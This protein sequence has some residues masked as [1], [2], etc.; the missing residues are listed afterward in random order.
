MS[1]LDVEK[2]VEGNK[3]GIEE[4]SPRGVLEDS[5]VSLDLKA[6]SKPSTSNSLESET[7]SPRASTSGSEGQPNSFVNTH[8]RDFF[9]VFRRGSTT[10]QIQTSPPP[11]K[12]VPKLTRWK[13]KRIRE[14]IVPALSSPLDAEFCYLKS[15]WKNFALSDLQAATNNF[16]RGVY[17]FQNL[18][19]HF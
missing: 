17:F 10:P 14:A 12:G 8:W 6:S 3:E 19:L 5:S 13:S 9:R 16:S 2:E 11:K 4:S 18:N 7:T 15:S 1:S